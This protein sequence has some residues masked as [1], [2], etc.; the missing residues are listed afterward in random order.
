MKQLLLAAGLALSLSACGINSVPTAEETAMAAWADVES[1]Y[2]RRA[3]LVDNLVNTVRGAAEQEEETLT[4]VIEARA[5]A[6]Q[7]NIDPGDLSDPAAIERYQAAQGELGSALSRLLVSVERYPELRSQ[8][9][10]LRLQDQLEGTENRIAV[11]RRDY[12]EA[13]RAYNTE[14]RT[15]PSLIAARFVYGS[16]RMEPFEA[17]TEGAETAP[18]VEF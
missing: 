16:E 7:V 9:G 11:A 6:T 4:R 2:Q 14:I 3:D 13:V 5:S 1:Q 18:T 12:N 10:F 15:F 8:E 17:V